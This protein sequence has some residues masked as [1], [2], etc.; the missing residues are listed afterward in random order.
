MRR[1]QVNVRE[2]ELLTF[3]FAQRAKLGFDGGWCFALTG[4]FWLVSLSLFLASFRHAV[5]WHGTTRAF[6]NVMR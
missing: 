2:F 6:L 5:I 1:D 4:C 3:L